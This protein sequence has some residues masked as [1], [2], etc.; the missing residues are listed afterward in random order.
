LNLEGFADKKADNLLEAIAASK[1]QPLSRLLTALGIR[2]VGETIAAD[3][4]RY[5]P[6][7]DMLAA[8]SAEDL[9]T[10]GGIGPNIA[11]AVVDWFARPA[12]QRV[13]SKLRS[14]GVWPRVEHQPQGEEQSQS[15][16]SYSF[17]V[18]GTLQNFTREEI[19]AYIQS[20]GGKVAGSVSQKTDY[21][22]AGENAGSK[23]AK[24][25][26]LGVQVISEE[27]LRLLAET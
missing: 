15:L 22:V 6:D 8:A 1:A 26:E 11:E 18:T 5:Y 4:T 7:L 9:Q 10:I 21:L 27:D 3:L 23:L 17:V 12:N 2:G 25:Q 20:F 13:L 24:A 14:A 19:K 16:A